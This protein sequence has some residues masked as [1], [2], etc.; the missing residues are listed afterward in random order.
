MVAMAT[1]CWILL[2]RSEVVMATMQGDGLLMRLAMAMMQPETTSSYLGASGLM[3][4]VM[5][6]AMMI[7]AVLPVVVTFSRLDRGGHRIDAALFGGGYLM[8]WSGFAILATVFQW[9]LHRA[10]LLHGHTLIAAP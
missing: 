9:T 3:W 4:V 1:A 5:M 2:A 10:S 8:V 6:A 7:P